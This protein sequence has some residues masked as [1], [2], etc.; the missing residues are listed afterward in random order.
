MENR[1]KFLH[2]PLSRNG[3]EGKQWKWKNQS[4]WRHLLILTDFKEQNINIILQVHYLLVQTWYLS[5]NIPNTAQKNVKSKNNTSKKIFKTSLLQ[6]SKN[7]GVKI[8][9]RNFFVIFSSRARQES[10]TGRRA[11]R[12]QGLSDKWPRRGK[13]PVVRGMSEWRGRIKGGDGGARAIGVVEAPRACGFQFESDL[14]RRN[15]VSL[16][17]APFSSSVAILCVPIIGAQFKNK[18]NRPR[19]FFECFSRKRDCFESITWKSSVCSKNSWG[20]AKGSK[21]RC[22]FRQGAPISSSVVHTC[23]AKRVG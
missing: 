23:G 14:T 11:V 1:K 12:F 13:F 8:Q 18:P 20:V 5:R 17:L 19:S 21:K 15:V 7:L 10:V 3:T 9:K 22:H 2:G 16:L 4:S 6:E